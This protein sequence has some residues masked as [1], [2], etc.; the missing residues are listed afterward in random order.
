MPFKRII[1]TSRLNTQLKDEAERIIQNIEKFGNQKNLQ[2]S[3]FSLLYCNYL[4]FNVV[5]VIEGP[6]DKVDELFKTIAQDVR[7]T[8]VSRLVDQLFEENERWLKMPSNGLKL[9]TEHEYQLIRKLINDYKPSTNFLDVQSIDL[10]ILD[11]LP[12]AG[13]IDL[14]LIRVIYKSRL[15]EM[16]EHRAF[17]LMQGIVEHAQIKNERLLIGG[18]LYMTETFEVVQ[19]LEGPSNSVRNLYK[20]IESD[21]RHSDVEFLL[22]EK[23]DKRK[24]KSWG[25]AWASESAKSDLNQALANKGK[26]GVL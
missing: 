20:V 3:M 1:Y 16:N 2:N 26:V 12:L 17:L 10:D 15:K 11:Q 8:K 14:S 23:I 18:V 13:D 5:H 19:C 4:T 6:I 25:M 22:L 9:S 21:P 24:Y 7:H